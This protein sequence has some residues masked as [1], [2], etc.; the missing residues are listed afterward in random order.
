MMRVAS[1][2]GGT[3]RWK[4]PRQSIETLTPVVPRGRRGIPLVPASVMVP[5]APSSPGVVE[6]QFFADTVTVR[7]RQSEEGATA[8][9][10]NGEGHGGETATYQLG[11]AIR[12]QVRL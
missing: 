3:L 6:A 10:V 9:A 7:Y 4:P 1:S 11:W 2:S 8:L 5:N 12:G